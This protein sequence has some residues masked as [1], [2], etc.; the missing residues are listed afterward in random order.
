MLELLGAGFG[1]VLTV[2]NLALIFAGTFLGIFVGA[3]PGL[4]SPVGLAIVLPFT[5]FL[6]PIPAML[7]MVALYMAA[8]YG[9]SITA[10]TIG[11]PGTSVAMATTF[12]GYPLARRGEAGLALGVSIVSS[13][14]GG[15]FGIIILMLAFTP[16][17]RFALVFGPREYFA[18]GVFGLAIVANMMSE[19]LI[20]GL[21][22]VILG[23]LFFLVGLDVMSGYPR[24]T[25]G[26]TNLLDGIQIVPALIGFFAIAEVLR[27]VEKSA[28]G[29][30]VPGHIS[31]RL[32]SL[33]ILRS[34][35]PTIL[36]GSTIGSLVGAV[37]G[38]GATIASV[39]AWNEERR[40]SKRPE[41][42]GHG[43]LA[44]V[45]APESANNASVAGAMIPLLALGI[46]GSA[47]TAVLLGGL[48]YH[49]VN[50]GP[51]LVREE[52]DLVYA[53]YAGLLVAAL[54]M[55]VLGVVAIPLW[56]KIVSVRPSILTPMVL[57]I[58]IAGSYS[59]AY[60][61]FDVWL[62]LFFG[63]LGYVM[64]RFGFPLVPAILGLVLGFMVETNYRRALA[65]SGGDHSTFISSPVTIVFLVLAALS[66]T[67]PLVR[68]QISARRLAAKVAAER[69]ERVPAE[70]P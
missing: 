31:G 20:K 6:D 58:S 65:L 51:L 40:F 41:E 7:M 27:L 17:A 67:I 36:R 57:G 33:K 64:L 15:I 49:G 28:A 10:I 59:L 48:M 26:T 61:I 16:I 2:Q 8:E 47:S 54:F 37:P 38:A 42:F 22:S 24:F 30:E 13:T 63:V 53:L 55:L 43:A 70:V 18:L 62:A 35:V 29:W 5:F 9:G 23:L 56:T 25:L 1:E 21:I 3:M 66:F 50:P 39:I 68:N 34:L 19:S 32:P 44:G 60:R 69:G 12:D 11:V 45:S 4:S 14:A 52:A 46:P